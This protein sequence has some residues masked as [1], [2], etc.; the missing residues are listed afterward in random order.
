MSASTPE[1]APLGDSLLSAIDRTKAGGASLTYTRRNMWETIYFHA[2]LVSFSV[3]LGLLWSASSGQTLPSQL[4]GVWGFGCAV[5]VI[6]S[7]FG[8]RA[9]TEAHSFARTD[10]WDASLGVVQTLTMV[11]ATFW[12]D[13]VSSPEWLAVLIGVVYLGT[14]LVY[15]AGLF[16]A[17][18]LVLMPTIS[19]YVATGSLPT[20]DTGDIAFLIGLTIALPASF[21]FIRG[22]SR[23]LYDVAEGTGWD[24]AELVEQVRQL[25]EAMTAASHGDL[26]ADVHLTVT[27]PQ[28]G[29]FAFERTRYIAELSQSFDFTLESL[30]GLVSR[31]R[32]GG[33]QIGAAASEVLVA[34]REQAAAASEQSSAVAETSATI[35]EL[36]ATAAQIAETA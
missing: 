31:V 1:T 10:P 22:T 9:A 24:Q 17:A 16:W 29:E 11:A 34:A 23:A 7:F 26:T 27:A 6:A 3:V 32:V 21:L 15:R 25:S 35:E 18:A 36:A 14:V 4:L 33:E 20:A 2:G 12:T 19:E 13:G 8:V 5:A 30:R 28:T